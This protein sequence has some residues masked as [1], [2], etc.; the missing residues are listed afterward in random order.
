MQC[1]LFNGLHIFQVLTCSFDG[2]V[3]ESFEEGLVS[4]KNLELNRAGQ[5]SVSSLT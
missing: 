2:Q 1:L 3:K 5:V 4:Y